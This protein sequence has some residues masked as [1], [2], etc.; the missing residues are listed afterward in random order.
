[1]TDVAALALRWS[2]TLGSMD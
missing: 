1:M 2:L